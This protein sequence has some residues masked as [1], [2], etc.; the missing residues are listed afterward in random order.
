MVTPVG[1]PPRP[2][3]THHFRR[4]AKRTPLN[5]D[6]RLI[7]HWQTL[8]T[9]PDPP[10]RSTLQHLPVNN[11]PALHEIPQLPCVPARTQGAFTPDPVSSSVNG[12]PGISLVSWETIVFPGKHHDF[13]NVTKISLT[14]PPVHWP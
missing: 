14:L 10:P 6:L 3:A 7:S 11:L 9:L 8:V 1:P 13:S 12:T 4:G 5:V 2:T